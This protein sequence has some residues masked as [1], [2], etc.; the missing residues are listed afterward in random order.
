[1][2][3]RARLTTNLLK[4]TSHRVWIKNTSVFRTEIYFRKEKAANRLRNFSEAERKRSAA[5][6]TP[7]NFAVFQDSLLYM[8][9]VDYRNKGDFVLILGELCQVVTLLAACL[10]LSENFSKKVCAKFAHT[11]QK[12]YL[13]KV[14]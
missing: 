6:G 3:R 9:Y 2:S 7:F 5:C 11:T 14:I 13:C 1:M 8:S 4:P 10:F 12:T